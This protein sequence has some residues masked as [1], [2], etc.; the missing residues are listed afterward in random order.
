MPFEKTLAHENVRK[1][2]K[3]LFQGESS[4]KHSGI[5]PRVHQVSLQLVRLLSLR[6]MSTATFCF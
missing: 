6:D 3:Y 4:E 1:L 5:P 2:H